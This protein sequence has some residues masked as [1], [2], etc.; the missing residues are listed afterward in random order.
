VRFVSALAV[1]A[2]GC[3]KPPAPDGGTP[4]TIAFRS[5]PWDSGPTAGRQLVSPHYRIYTTSASPEVLHYLPGFLEAAHANYLAVTGL[6]PR[7][8]LPRMSVY[9]MASRQEWAALTRSIVGERWSIY[10]AIEA[11]GYC[12]RGVSVFWDIGGIGSMSIAA[13]EGLHQFLAHRL[14]EPLPMWLEE[15]LAAVCEGYQLDGLRVRFTPTR[16]PSRFSDLRKGLVQGWWVPL[17]KLLEMDGGDALRGSMPERAVMYYGQLW[18]LAQYLAGD[19]AH[20]AGRARLL[21]DAQAGRLGEALNVPADRWRALRRQG[22][23]YNRTMSVPLFKHY[24]TDDLAGF[25]R[26][27]VAFARKLAKLE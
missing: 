3:G 20:A 22:R 4:L 11:G 7:P 8:D 9:M 6:A 14:A 18:A 13:H 1:A 25:E 10:A 19:P 16:N 27:Y 2:G 24:V 15:G 21:A 26:Q 23:L 17:A 5:E 12:Y